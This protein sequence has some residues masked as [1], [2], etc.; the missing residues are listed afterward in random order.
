MKKKSVKIQL[1]HNLSDSVQTEQISNSRS[2][3]ARIWYGFWNGLAKLAFIVGSGLV[4]VVQLPSSI[5]RSASF[6]KFKA[7]QVKSL[8]GFALL[9]IIVL[10]PFL[11]ASILG[12]GWKLGGSVLGIGDEAL[13]D[14]AQAREAVSRQDYQLAQ[15]NFTDAL[16]KLEQLH[17]QLNQSSVLIQ[18][19][20]K[21][22][23]AN[24]NTN[25]LLQAATNL[26]EAGL[27]A[28]VLLS[29]ISSLNFTSQ[30]FVSTSGK[31]T[32]Q[33]FELLIEQSRILNEKLSNANQL[34]A[35]LSTDLLPAEYQVPVNE[36]KLLL[37]DLSKQTDQLNALAELMGQLMLGQKSYLVILQNNNELRAS[38]GFIGTIA[39]GQLN[40]GLVESLDI[41][42]VYDLDGQLLDWIKPP[43]PLQ[44]VNSRLFLRD[45]NWFVDF[46]ESAQQISVMYEKSSGETPDLIVAITPDVFIKFLELTGPIQLP[47]YNVTITADNFIEQIQTTT[48]VAYDKEL[49]Q[50]KQLLADLYPALMQRINELSQGQPIIM[51][52]LMQQQLNQKNIQLYSRDQELQNK[53]AEYRWNGAV[54]DTEGDYLQINSTNL[55]GSKTDLFLERSAGLNTDIEVSGKVRHQLTYTIKNPLPPVAGLNNKSWVRFLVPSGAKLLGSNGFSE[56]NLA[57]LPAVT[58]STLE[59]VN[60]WENSLNYDK[61]NRVYTGTEAGKTLFAGWVDVEPGDST[62]VSINY[63]L[64]NSLRWRV[65]R[66]QLLIEKQSGVSRLQ[67]THRIN[68]PGRELRWSSSGLAAA[69]RADDAIQYQTD[70]SVDSFVGFVLT[71]E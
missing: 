65:S 37:A 12:E 41:R 53:L 57:D 62:T 24:I 47:T 51:L 68:F 54:T 60:Q 44:A 13:N 29:E 1:H 42:T 31:T 36:A 38:G 25:N 21:Y 52:G 9:I 26:T 6:P 7:Q 58:Y 46:P 33:S 30:G 61:G 11:S 35:P 49:N 14:I 2:V 10:I 20:S 48:S 64:P 23:P 40:D 55:N 5:F 28:T 67:L 39:Q 70:L 19:T 63:E 43:S 22:A 18:A 8:G 4:S 34:L 71:P 59:Q 69:E 32:K 15:T 16:V 56:A 17:N 27:A 50:P 3:I 66:Y 45:S